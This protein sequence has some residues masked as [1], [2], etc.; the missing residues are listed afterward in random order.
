MKSHKEYA[1]QL[2]AIQQTL[3]E[4]LTKLGEEFRKD[5]LIPLCKK[6]GWTFREGDFYKR[7]EDNRFAQVKW[8]EVGPVLGDYQ[9]VFLEEV[10]EDRAF[11]AW[12]PDVKEEDLV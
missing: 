12:T 6:H 4:S 11:W 3:H 7:R 8:Q 9:F 1:E 2:E 10:V 5:V